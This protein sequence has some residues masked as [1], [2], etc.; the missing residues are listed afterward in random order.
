MNEVLE[1]EAFAKHCLRLEKDELDWISRMKDQLATDLLVGKP[2]RFSWFRE[3]KF[4]NRRLFYVI[5]E[6]T[7]RALIISFESKKEQQKVI[8]NVLRNREHYLAFID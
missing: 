4:G 8:N 7:K 2:L 6:N 3:K 1:L 5:N